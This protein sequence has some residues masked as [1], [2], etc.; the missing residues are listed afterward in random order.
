MNNA[1]QKYAAALL[2]FFIIVVGASQTILGGPPDFQTLVPFAI[3]VAGAIATFIVKLI[4]DVK[5][6]GGLKTGIA[7]FS[8][9]LT[10]LVPFLLPGG[11]QLSAN[12]PIV[13]V[14]ILNA[15]ATE[16]GVQIRV[17]PGEAS[18]TAVNFYNIGK[19][20]DIS[21]AAPVVDTPVA[22]NEAPTPSSVG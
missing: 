8:T 22:V 4:P 18:P 19:S 10:A 16:L 12:L 13:I 6:Q 17:A 7:I 21:A 3:I 9:I 20:L 14:A 1:F 15:L 11:F 5:W 2:P